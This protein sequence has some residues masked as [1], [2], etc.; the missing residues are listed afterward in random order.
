MMYPAS[1][2]Y[3]AFVASHTCTTTILL[4]IFCCRYFQQH[5][6][7]TQQAMIIEFVARFIKTDVT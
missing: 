1:N 6:S 2:L 3:F 4:S 5:K 7:A